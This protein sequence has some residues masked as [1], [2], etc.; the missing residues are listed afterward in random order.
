MHFG[1][2]P[3]YLKS[4]CRS[5]GTSDI[6][7]AVKSS[8]SNINNGQGALIW[9]SR[10][11]YGFSYYGSKN[12]PVSGTTPLPDNSSPSTKYYGQ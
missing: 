1:T 10:Q 7:I 2:F 8:Y 4:L 11:I 9:S 5:G 6:H 12:Y 3:Q